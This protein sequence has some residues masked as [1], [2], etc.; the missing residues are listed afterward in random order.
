MATKRGAEAMGVGDKVGTLEAGKEADLLL[1]D[2][3]KSHLT[4]LNDPF[5]ALVYAAQSSDIDTV[6]CQGKILMEQR[7]VRTLDENK[8]MDDVQRSWANI[9]KR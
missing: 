2:L 8:V 4:P 6:F 3:K 1:I 5:S 9:L 7:K